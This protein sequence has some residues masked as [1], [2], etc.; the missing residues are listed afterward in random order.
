[1]KPADPNCTTEESRQQPAD[2]LRFRLLHEVV[3][4]LHT[5]VPVR[6][7]AARTCTPSWSFPKR[8]PHFDIAVRAALGRSCWHFCRCSVT[9]AGKAQPAAVAV[10]AGETDCPAS[11]CWFPSGSDNPKYQ[12]RQGPSHGAVH[13]RASCITK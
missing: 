1:M 12:W 6:G 5:L 13:R 10:A 7:N 9:Q 11:T 2:H 3:E 4:R 8:S